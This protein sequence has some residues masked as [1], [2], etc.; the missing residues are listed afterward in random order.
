MREQKNVVLSEGKGLQVAALRKRKPAADLDNECQQSGL[1]SKRMRLD[2][3]PYGSEG[4]PNL[5]QSIDETAASSNLTRAHQVDAPDVLHGKA[6]QDRNLFLLD[7]FCGTAGVAAA[8]QSL[9]GEALGID[10]L[11]DKRRVKGPVAKVDLSKKAGQDTVIKWIQERKVDGVMLAPPCGTSS[12]AREIPL[13]RKLRGRC[14]MQ[15]EP[16][17]S[18]DWPNGLPHLKGIAQLK[19]KAANKLYAFT[20]RVI[21]ACMDAGIPFICENPR[22]SLM[23]KTDAFSDLPEG[24]LFQYIHACMYGSKRRKST[25]LLMNF[26]AENLKKECDNSHDHLPWGMVD[27]K[28][29][30][31]LKFSTSL[32]TEYP[33]PLCKQLALA[34]LEHMQCHGKR[35]KLQDEQTEQLQ[36]MGSGTQPRGGR[37]PVLMAEFQFKVDITT[38]DATPPRCIAEDSPPPF[39]GIPVGAKLIS[40]REVSEVGEEGEKKE[41]L[42]A[43]YGVFSSPWDFLWR[44][45]AVEH[46][47][48]TPQLVDK[49]NLRAIVFLR[50][51][52]VAEVKS[53][54]AKQ[55]RRFVERAET[56]KTDEEALKAS[57][58]GDVRAVLAPKRLLLFKEMMEEAGVAD[59]GLFEEL[60]QGFA[61]TGD[62]PESGQFPAKLKPAMISVQQLRDSAVW[63]KRMIQTSCKRVG[64]DAE[65][66]K[67][68]Y[69]ETV[70]QVADGWVKGPFSEHDLDLKYGG[71]WIPSKRFGVR[72]G[73]KVRAVDDFSEFLINAS[74]TSTERLQLFGIDE[75]I[76]TARTFLGADLLEVSSDFSEAWGSQGLRAFKGPWKSLQGRALD[77]KAAYKQLARH[78]RDSWASILAVWNPSASK[79]EFYES[80]ALPFGS[81]CAVM[82]FNRVARALRL[83]MSE[84]FMIVNTNF[85]DD[86]CQLEEDQLCS[87]SWETAEM[88]MRLLGWKIS[89]SDD[90]R[91]PF[92]V[93][94]QMLGAVIDLSRSSQGIVQV[95]NKP[96]R[97]A[98]IGAM[99]ED[100]CQRDSIPLSTIETL[101]G[102]LLYAAGHTFGRCTQLS[103]QLISRLARRGPMVLLD[104]KFKAVVRDAFQCLSRAPAREVGAWSGR[105]PIVVFTDGACENEGTEITHG[106]TLFDPET[107]RALMFGDWVPDAWV[108]KWKAGG[109]KQLICQAEIF[110]VLVSKATWKEELRHRAILWFI[111]NNAALSAVIRSFSPV[112]ENYELLVLNANL[113]LQ[114]QSMQWY[115]RVPSK[116]N[117]SD[118]A[119]RL[120]F[121]ELETRGF[122]RCKPQYG[123]L[124]MNESGVEA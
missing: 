48:D 99:V 39:Q 19:V 79:V 46:P 3:G 23:W 43:T 89:M 118:S 9:G 80:V 102:R 70:Q 51:H 8:F 106:A 1:T 85:F 108:Q 63:A 21:Q 124:T 90:K 81:V 91:L 2:G 17:R 26:S 14:G 22:R 92:G 72:Q 44:A 94:F 96:S 69:D 6:H 18:D 42:K 16:L 121:Q 98:D 57:L 30:A 36:K 77:L 40:S 56:L 27:A 10:H 76:N 28:D 5:F 45:L 38:F 35:L 67:A 4:I 97:M 78:P 62:M 74:V 34:F 11:V 117:L 7:I 114:L 37:A 104:D 13:P 59:K 29:G 103:I 49:S 115:A 60:T 107:G 54:R 52:S 82:A 87:S 65:I 61:L 47:L 84:L 110:P 116:S 88:V 109:K 112:I 41:G 20:R 58:D 111:D 122:L 50:D 105:Q 12:R 32:E 120:D 86:F 33:G 75:V 15:P 64:L 119:S 100:L 83:I 68:V 95:R 55:L 123:S 31:G 73:Q 113:D 71:C 24:C 93:E 53:F 25:A 66:A 101:K